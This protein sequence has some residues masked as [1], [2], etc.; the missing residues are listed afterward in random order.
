VLTPTVVAGQTYFLVVDGYNGAA[1]SFAL[2]LTPPPGGPTTTT[3]TST[4]T[5]STSNT[6]PTTTSTSTTLPVGSCG[7]PIALPAEGGTFT[8]V[9]SGSS[10]LVA[11]CMSAS[12]VSPEQVYQWTAPRSGTATIQ[13]CSTVGTTF[14][15]VAYL[16]QGTCTGGTDVACND[17]TVGCGTTTDVSNPHR[18]SVLTPT[19]V[20]GQTYYLVV[21]GYNGAQGSFVLTVAPPP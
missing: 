8:G 7:T 11:S 13:T 10:A 9:T 15:T 12:S 17:D 21:D 6:T 18:G 14:D 4:S 2:T 19:V 16:R 20:A 1:G 3:S 5:T